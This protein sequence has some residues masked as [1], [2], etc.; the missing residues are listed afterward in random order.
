MECEDATQ[1]VKCLSCSKPSLSLPFLS[2]AIR[3]ALS[4]ISPSFL[5]SIT[6]QLEEETSR[7][8]VINDVH[9][10]F[11]RIMPWV[12]PGT[13]KYPTPPQ[14]LQRLKRFIVS[15]WIL[16]RERETTLHMLQEWLLTI[17]YTGEAAER[18]PRR[19]IRHVTWLTTK[20]PARHD[21]AS[22]R[23]R[24][25]GCCTSMKFESVE[26]VLKRLRTLSRAMGRRGRTAVKMANF[27]C[28]WVTVCPPG[29]THVTSLKRQKSR[30]P[31]HEER[32]VDWFR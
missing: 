31:C 23:K 15:W 20:P 22:Q 12:P 29:S 18:R 2:F 4:V 25:F 17:I 10:C 16:R 26:E 1:W 7:L 5:L 14:S 32:F 19:Q 11:S 3:K 9:V 28:D 27:L 6:S 13:P 8:S 24:K 21:R 30:L